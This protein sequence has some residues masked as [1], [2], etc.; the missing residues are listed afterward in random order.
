MSMR[1]L[2]F[3]LLTLLTICLAITAN[4]MPA[5]DETDLSGFVDIFDGETLNGWQNFVRLSARSSAGRRAMLAYRLP[6]IAPGTTFAWHKY[7]TAMM[8]MSGDPEMPEWADGYVPVW[9][10]EN[11]DTVWMKVTSFTPFNS[12][13]VSRYGNIPIPN[14][15]AIW[16]QN[17][18][19]NVAYKSAGGV[20]EFSRTSVPY[21]EKMTKISTGEMYEFTP[22]GKLREVVEQVPF[23]QGVVHMFPITQLFEQIILPYEVNEYDALGVPRPVMNPD[24]SY[25][26]P[27]ELWQVL[28]T[29]V[30]GPKVM[31]RN[32][33]QMI[34]SEQIRARKVIESYRAMYHRADPE[35]KEFIREAIE[36]YSRGLYRKFK[37]R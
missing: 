34:R 3:A 1:N 26:Y 21:G 16:K 23:I 25:K 15:A 33:E 12:L 11:G 4:T 10:R 2:S 35:R 30:G 19:I 5:Q 32:R 20:D 28:N 24:G 17:P 37:G 6:F 36:D 9:A 18:F 14:I 31:T 8:T 22:D 13:G 29:L 7:A 27:R